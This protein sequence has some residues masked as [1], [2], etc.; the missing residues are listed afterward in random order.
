MEIAYP[1]L[2]TANLRHAEFF[3]SARESASTSLNLNLNHS[4][5]L[6]LS[7]LVSKAEKQMDLHW[8]LAWVAPTTRLETQNIQATRLRFTPLQG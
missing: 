5:S 3:I 1:L 2:S 8:V 6:S 7:S 4:E